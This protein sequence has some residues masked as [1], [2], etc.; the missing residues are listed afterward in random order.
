M[1][2]EWECEVLK[3]AIAI[4]REGGDGGIWAECPHA[5]K[6]NVDHGNWVAVEELCLVASEY[7]QCNA[8]Q[9]VESIEKQ[10]VP[11]VEKHLQQHTYSMQTQEVEGSQD[12][13]GM[14]ARLK[15]GEE[16]EEWRGFGR[17]Q[18]VSDWMQIA[19]CFSS[20][21]AHMR[22]LKPEVKVLAGS[23]GPAGIW[24]LGAWLRCQPTTRKKRECTQ[25][26][27]VVGSAV[28]YG[29]SPE[30]KVDHKRRGRE[31][32]E[33]GRG[34]KGAVTT[35]QRAAKAKKQAEKN[36]T[37]PLTTSNDPSAHPAS[38]DSV[39]HATPKIGT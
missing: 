1:G 22:A 27:Q 23:D 3:A 18:F 31:G 20:Q 32:K 38:L 17:S 35:H 24:V 6:C 13:L 29:H 4:A 33:V 16:G 10:D 21:Y 30:G 8:E 14:W 9:D 34:V 36:L 2:R 11:R 39:A 5:F 28:W 7:G 15:K 37:A 26:L 25:D 19:L 12:R